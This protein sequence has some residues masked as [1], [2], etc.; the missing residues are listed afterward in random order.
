M[1][2]KISDDLRK[3]F[4]LRA[5]LF[6]LAAAFEDI[7]VA[8]REYDKE[9]EKK[10]CENRPHFCY[11][12]QA[13][14]EIIMSGAAKRSAENNVNRMNERISKLK[15]RLF[16]VLAFAVTMALAI[17]CAIT[18]LG[19][20]VNEVVV[21]NHAQWHV[22][23]V[24][25]LS[26]VAIPALIFAVAAASKYICAVRREIS[27]Y[28][29]I[30]SENKSFL[31]DLPDLRKHIEAVRKREELKISQRTDDCE[32]FFKALSKKY[33]PL[34]DMQYWRY[35][36][37]IIY[38]FIKGLSTS[39]EEIVDLIAK[40]GAQACEGEAA[41]AYSEL[42]KLGNSGEICAVKLSEDYLPTG[43]YTATYEQ[44][45]GKSA[46]EEAFHGMFGQSAVSLSDRVF[47]EIEKTKK[48]TV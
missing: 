40:C 12:G 47:A 37:L 46:L 14:D 2:K 32:T 33:A 27:E 10:Y 21:S 34:L 29:E 28:T 6:A 15:N 45:F 35:C 44:S 16:K 42:E 38:R 39:L 18:V 9:I 24:V 30:L 17:V 25:I 1:D 20:S 36:D 7:D 3:I 41:D 19:F 26:A 5:G 48:P 22:Y 31:N 11:L 23:V 8:R 43:D 4:T 13:S